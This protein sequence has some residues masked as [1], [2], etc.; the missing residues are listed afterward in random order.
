MS[1]KSLDVVHRI[2]HEGDAL[3]VGDVLD[4]LHLRGRG[5][6]ALGL[7]L[8]GK[9]FALFG[10]AKDVAGT[11]LAITEETFLSVVGIG[12]SAGIIPPAIIPLDGKVI[13][14]RLLDV[15]F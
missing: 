1:K 5:F 14:N 10:Q 8:N 7:D 6:L 2:G 12:H 9:E 3:V 11:S 15:L 13:Q 4:E